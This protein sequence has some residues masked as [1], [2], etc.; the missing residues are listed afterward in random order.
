MGDALPID[1]ECLYHNES[2]RRTSTDVNRFSVIGNSHEAIINFIVKWMNFFGNSFSQSA[3]TGQRT[4]TTPAQHTVYWWRWCT[5]TLYTRV[6]IARV[7]I[8]K[9]VCNQLGG[10]GICCCCHHMPAQMAIEFKR[11]K[12]KNERKVTDLWCEWLRWKEWENGRVHVL[13]ARYDVIR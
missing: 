9:K 13:I 12:M 1:C 7:N 4:T 2:V 10:A 6:P 8:L 11:N 5:W 3:P